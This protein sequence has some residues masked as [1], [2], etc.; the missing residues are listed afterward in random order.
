MSRRRRRGVDIADRE[1]CVDEQVEG[2]D[3]MGAVPYHAAPPVLQQPAGARTIAA[4][5]RQR[6]C[7][8]G[9]VAAGVGA[10][11]SVVEKLIGLLEPALADAQVGQ[12][13]QRLAMKSGA[14]PGRVLDADIELLLGLRPPSRRYQHAAVIDAALGIEEGAAVAFDE[15]VGHSTPLHSP[16]GVVDQ[17]TGVEHVAARVHDGH[18]V[19][20]FAA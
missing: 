3:E 13:G 18:Q 8:Q 6:G 20:G 7:R 11:A 2:H 14:R 12:A 10:D 4:S 15:L 1:V 5:E 17:L 19:G 9:H 16:L